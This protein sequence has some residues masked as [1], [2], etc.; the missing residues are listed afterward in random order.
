M[1]RLIFCDTEELSCDAAL[2]EAKK[3]PLPKGATE[4]KDMGRACESIASYILLY[5][6][7][8]SL[9]S[10][11][12]AEIKRGECGKP[13]IE[14]SPVKFSV[15]HR[16]GVALVA[17]SDEGEI[18][19]DIELCLSEERMMG[20]GKRYL[21]GLDFAAAPTFDTE[22]YYSS[23]S[24][25]GTVENF[26]DI[27]NIDNNTLQYSTITADESAYARW[28]VLEA[29]LKLDGGGFGALGRAGE[30]ISA[31]QIHAAMIDY[32]GRS[33]AV[34]AARCAMTDKI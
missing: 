5:Y 3:I 12:Y 23:L 18:G 30:L 10:I 34:C 2:R 17:L 22:I 15:S 7:L 20:I 13:Y 19:T 25:G 4:E 9:Y 26:T 29:V 6:A 27:S 32:R 33:Y 28:T 1:I 21:D 14:G 8:T 24:A 31:S 16:K 11:E